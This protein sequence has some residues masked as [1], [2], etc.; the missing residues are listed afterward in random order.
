MLSGETIHIYRHVALIYFCF[1]YYPFFFRIYEA[2]AYGSVPVIEDVMTPGECGVSPA[3]KM[4]PLRLLKELE[5]PV[6]YVK[7]W[8][9]DLPKVK[10]KKNE[11]KTFV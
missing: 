7:N 2:M 1:Y 9:T 3:S 8:A 11:I 6:I 5:A 4:Y 10:M